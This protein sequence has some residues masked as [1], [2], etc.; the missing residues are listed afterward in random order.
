MKTDDDISI[1]QEKKEWESPSF[2]VIP[3]NNTKGGGPDD[4]PETMTY[5]PAA[6]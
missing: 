1:S 6:S 5:N 2:Q 3:F 4:P